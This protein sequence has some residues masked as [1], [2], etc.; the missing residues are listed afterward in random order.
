MTKNN[1]I[2]SQGRTSFSK[3]S[4]SYSKSDMIASPDTNNAMRENKEGK[5]RYDLLPPRAIHRLAK[6]FEFGAKKYADRDHEK[7]ISNKQLL[8]SALRHTFQYMKGDNSEDHL[9]AAVW[10]L[11]III[12]QEEKDGK[13]DY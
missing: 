5:G 2:N 13:T 7:G 8:D 1:K 10:N 3:K 9:S 11:M 4:F 6:R 12:E